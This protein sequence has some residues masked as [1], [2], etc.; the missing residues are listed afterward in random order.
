[1]NAVSAIVPA[2][3]NS[4]GH[5]PDPA[6]ILFAILGGK[7]QAEPLGELLAMPLLEHGRRGIQS[8]ADIIAV[9]HKAAAARGNAAC[10]R[11]DSR[12]CSC[13]RRLSP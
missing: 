11:P 12:S 3:R 5:G 1:M 10:D 13:R 7:T 4:F 8:V 6:D 2:W 9:E